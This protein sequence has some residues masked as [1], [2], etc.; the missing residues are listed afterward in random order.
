[1]SRVLDIVAAQNQGIGDQI[2]QTSTVLS[3]VFSASLL[4]LGVPR[5]NAGQFGT[6]CFH[7]S[8]AIAKAGCAHL[9]SDIV[10]DKFTAKYPATKFEIFVTSY[11]DKL[12]NGGYFAYA[13][14][15]VIPR[16]ELDLFPKQRVNRMLLEVNGDPT[17]AQLG[18]Q[19]EKAIRSA[20]GSLMKFCEA[21]PTCDLD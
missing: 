9:L 10:T 3:I 18:E 7:E 13:V 5:A 14:A 4:A 11:S 19:E 16:S 8:D 20:V 15:G 12:T 17:P 6:H 2:M 1:L 21:L